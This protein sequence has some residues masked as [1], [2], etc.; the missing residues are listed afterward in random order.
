MK[1]EIIIDVSEELLAA[2]DGWAAYLS[3]SRDEFVVHAVEYFLR[4]KDQTRIAEI[5][6][7]YTA[8]ESDPETYSWENGET[9][10]GPMNV[11]IA[12]PM[13]RLESLPKTLPAD[14]GVCLEL[15]EGIPIFRAPTAVQERIKHL[16]EK[17]QDTRLSAEEDQE[18]DLYEEVDDYLSFV[19]RTVR[20]RLS[21]R[22]DQAE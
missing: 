13:P 2:V 3:I 7:I 18:L 22:S 6:E 16:L 20:D 21:V 1:S 8:I 14:R 17:Q 9:S 12:I 11:A 4:G 19:N 10:S 15:E 5:R